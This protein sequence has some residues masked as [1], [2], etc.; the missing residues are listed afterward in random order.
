MNVPLKEKPSFSKSSTA[1]HRN[2]ES[3][4][5]QNSIPSASI[6]PT[7]IVPFVPLLVPNASEDVFS[8]P[9]GSST[10]GG[11][12]MSVGAA[13]VS[14]SLVAPVSGK[15]QPSS[16]SSKPLETIVDQVFDEMPQ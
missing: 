9:R 11:S 14:L 2:A 8:T 12:G 1:G 10:S 5:V 15:R 16:L 7:A 3:E 13:L 6:F 4:K